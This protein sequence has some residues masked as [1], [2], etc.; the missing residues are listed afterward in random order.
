MYPYMCNLQFLINKVFKLHFIYL[1]RDVEG[2]WV[3]YES[4][5]Y[6]TFFLIEGKPT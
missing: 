1:F 2:L 6:V 4:D 5:K 3:L